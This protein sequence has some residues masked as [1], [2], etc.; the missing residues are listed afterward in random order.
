MSAGRGS[1]LSVTWTDEVTGREG[2]LVVDRLIRGLA[3]GGLRMRDGCTVEEVR[4]LAEAMTRKEAL[5]YTPGARYIP[6]GGA[7]GGIDCDPRSD[8][9]QGMLTRYLVAMG[10]YLERVWATGEDLGLTQTMIDRAVADAG[11]ESSIQALDPYLDDPDRAKARLA[12]GFAVTVDGVGLDTLVGG[13]GVAAAAL[14]ALDQL[15]RPR[16]ATRAFI[17][18]FGSMGGATARYLVKAGVAVVG[19]SDADG[20]IANPDGLDVEHLLRHRDHLGAIDRSALGAADTQLPRDAWLDVDAELLVPAAVSYAIDAV[21]ADRVR[22]GLVVEA[23]N[24][25]VTPPAEAALTARGVTIVPDV[26]ANSATNSWWW[27]TLF[28]DIG[29]TADEA[30]ARI[31]TAMGDLVGRLFDRSA[32]DG[33]TLRAAAHAIAEENHADLVERWGRRRPADLG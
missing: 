14:V 31:D 12:A 22:A 28:G 5:N 17:Q 6:L 2:Y 29:P 4:G 8:E 30:F 16:A 27:W 18:G 19:V 26:V 25:P 15:D 11:L 9:A 13:Y 10:P 7:K 23:A 20:V 3:S 33:T 32:K 1:Y 21:D 24:L